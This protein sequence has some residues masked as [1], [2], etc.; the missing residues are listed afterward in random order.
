L[1][2]RPAI[3]GFRSRALHAPRVSQPAFTDP[4][5]VATLVG[6]AAVGAVALLGARTALFPPPEESVRVLLAVVGPAALA[7][8]VARRL[9]GPTR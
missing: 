3:A 4:D 5:Y 6:V 7:H 1:G 9:R 8:A 2:P